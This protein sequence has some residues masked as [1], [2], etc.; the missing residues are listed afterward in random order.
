MSKKLLALV[1]IGRI[2]YEG[3]EVICVFE[4]PVDGAAWVAAC[5]AHD[6]KRPEC[7][8]MVEDTAVNDAAWEKHW[9]K[10]Q[11]WLKKHP[12]RGS[13]S[14]YEVLTVP[15]IASKP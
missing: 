9:K 1:G 2:D 15:F 8:V 12:A 11:S 6:H 3:Q 7:P 5:Q 14:S 10:H 4:T 13:Y